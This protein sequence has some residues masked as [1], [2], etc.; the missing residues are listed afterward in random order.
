MKRPPS[1]LFPTAPKR[2]NGKVMKTQNLLGPLLLASLLTGCGGSDSASSI[3]ANPFAGAYNGIATLDAGR[4]GTLTASVSSTGALTGTFAVAAAP[5]ATPGKNFSFSIG[6]F[7]LTGTVDA[8]GTLNATG[9]DPI[10]G[11]FT[12]TG[13]LSR[14]G[15]GSYTIT[16]G[17]DSYNGTIS[18][19]AGGGSG[20]LTISNVSG[21]NVNTAAW[22]GTPFLLI[23]EAG[24]LSAVLAIPSQTD[25]TR[26]LNMLLEARATS[27]TDYP[28]DSSNLNS[29]TI[30]TYTDGI[31]ANAKTWIANGGTF[32]LISKSAGKIKLQLVN[33]TFAPSAAAGNPATGTFTLNA[34]LEK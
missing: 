9:T 19:S 30:F 5:T 34:T 13:T 20:N 32:R 23:S 27:G 22:S 21:S 17:G 12:I 8:S 24:G 33:A 25:N 4:T 16:A 3:A 29:V 31:G 14:T 1:T 28:I 15:N 11:A 6:T 2:P 7:N 26:N 18:V 10:G